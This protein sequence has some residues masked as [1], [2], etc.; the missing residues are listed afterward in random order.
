MDSW[1]YQM[2]HKN[3]LKKLTMNMANI[4]TGILSNHEL[5]NFGRLVKNVGEI[6]QDQETMK[7]F[8]LALLFSDE[9][10]S[11]PEMAK[12]RNTYLSIIKR[13]TNYLGRKDDDDYSENSI[14]NLA[15]GQLV[16]SRFSS[17]VSSCKELAIY[18]I[19]VMGQ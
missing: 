11:S 9:E 15:F 12:L 13:R 17:C 2:T 7:L 10:V 14:E 4:S 8:T 19:K 16:Y 6:L 1:I 3:N 18:C 5:E